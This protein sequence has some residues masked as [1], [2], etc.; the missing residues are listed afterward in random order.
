MAQQS[1]AAIIGKAAIDKT[2]LELLKNDPDKVIAQ[3]PDLTDEDKKVVKQL[4][5]QELDSLHAVTERTQLRA[6]IDKKDA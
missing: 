3:Y 4:S 6:F 2:F 5:H 1:L